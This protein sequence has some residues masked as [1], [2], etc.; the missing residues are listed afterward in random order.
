MRE[1]LWRRVIVNRLRLPLGSTGEIDAAWVRSPEFD[2]RPVHQ[3]YRRVA[4][5]RTR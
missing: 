2:V 3:V 5:N 1:I 4:G